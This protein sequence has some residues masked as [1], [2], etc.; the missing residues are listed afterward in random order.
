[1]SKKNFSWTLQNFDTKLLGFGVAKIEEVNFE[2]DK[3]KLQKIVS[4]LIADLRFSNISYATYRVLANSFPL[5][6]SLERAGFLIVDGMIA[7]EADLNN[8]GEFS[9]SKIIR[10]AEKRDYDFLKNLASQV[11][12][13]T[14]FYNDPVIS[15]ERADELYSSWMKN[16]LN[17]KVADMVL[18]WEEHGQI[19]G[20]I[21]LQ[22][23]GHIPL[24]GVSQEARGRG[25][26][27]E[28]VRAAFL[29]FVKNDC[30]KA[31]IETQIVNIPALRAYQSCGFKVVNSYLTFRWTDLSNISA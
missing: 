29:E 7:L 15:K 16:S 30:S 21:T 17:G 10:K 3:N 4:E 24:I 18:V 22:K 23:N 11:F 13:L 5:I 14:R 20:F 2:Q 31:F 28:L 19:L 25:I 6:H 9:V 26:A 8:I 27:K 1:M 12:S